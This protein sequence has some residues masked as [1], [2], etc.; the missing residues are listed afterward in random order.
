MTKIQFQFLE[1]ARTNRVDV[2]GMILDQRACRLDV[3]NNLDRTALHLAA[4]NG[5]AEAV[6]MLVAARAPLDTQDKVSRRRFG[7]GFR[8]L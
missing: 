6:Q 8:G 4:A 5:C 3:K 7:W 2:L 1:A